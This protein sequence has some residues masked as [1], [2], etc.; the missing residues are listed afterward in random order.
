MVVR[1]H[2]LKGTHSY[3]SRAREEAG[4]NAMERFWKSTMRVT[5]RFLTVAALMGSMNND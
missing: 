1:G 5:G 4:R 2:P 3:Q